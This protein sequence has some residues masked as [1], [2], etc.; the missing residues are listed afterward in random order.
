MAE[1]FPRF[2]LKE[3]N[4]F[5]TDPEKIL[6][7]IITKYEEKIGGTL[8]SGDPRR[9]FLM[10]IADILIQIINNN[11]ITAQQ[12]LLSYSQGIFLDALGYYLQC[13][14]L[15]ASPAVTTLQFTLSQALGN[16][17]VIPAGFEVT[18]GQVTFATNKELVIEAGALTGEMA[19]TCT[20][21]GV[22]G[23]DYFAGQIETIVTPLTFLKKAM[24]ITTTAGGEDVESDESYAIRI[25][26][27]PNK[28]STAGAEGAYKYHAL[29]ANPAII[30][31]AV[32]SPNPGEVKL[33]PLLTDGELPTEDVLNSIYEH[34]SAKNKRPMTDFVEVLAPTK[35]E[36]SISIDYWINEEDVANSEAIQEMVKSAVEKYRLWQQAKIGRDIT[37]DKLIANVMSVGIARINFTTLSPSEWVKL[38]E[39][40]VAQCT[41][42]TINYNG[43]KED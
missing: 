33:Y 32:L 40:E 24:N 37:P 6:S 22:I 13:E 39:N 3:V 14:R 16:P 43:S 42:V 25:Q 31:I 4:F 20:S 17:Y 2:N 11:N 28:F 15:Q 18:N 36:Y 7:E 34:V 27:A 29:T 12:G 5:E 1:T 10:S 9:L 26:L 8:A 23:N 30:D 41:S 38:E 21:T 19:A 35:K